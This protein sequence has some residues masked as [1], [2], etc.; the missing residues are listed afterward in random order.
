M[1]T[2]ALTASAAHVADFVESSDMGQLENQLRVALGKLAAQS[3]LVTS[4]TLSG[5]G[6]GSVFGVLVEATPETEIVS[7]NGIDPATI[8]PQL[9]SASSP[10]A[11]LKERT[12]AVGAPPTGFPNVAD[13]QID[14]AT[15]GKLFAGLVLFSTFSHRVCER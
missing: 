9:F 13:V 14:G 11:L 15:K 12:A 8:S 2:Y 5:A 4:L 7:G 1:T 10:G 3:L 6:D